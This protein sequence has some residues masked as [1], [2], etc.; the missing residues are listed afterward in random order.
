MIMARDRMMDKFKDLRVIG[1]HMGC[2]SFD[3]DEVA[4][5]FDRYPNFAV[6]TSSVKG[7]LMGQAREKIREFSHQQSDTL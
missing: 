7:Y 3:T 5:H 2:M 6:D 4:R 1:C